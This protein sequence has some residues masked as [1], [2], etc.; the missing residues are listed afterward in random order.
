VIRFERKYPICRSLALSKGDEEEIV[1]KCHENVF[2]DFVADKC[3]VDGWDSSFTTDVTLL[4]HNNSMSTAELL[5]GF[6]QFY[7][8]FDFRAYVLC[9][10]LGLAV[11]VAAFT[12]RQ[13]SDHAVKHFKV[14]VIGRRLVVLVALTN[15]SRNLI[16]DRSS[17]SSDF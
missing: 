15:Q 5:T 2:V 17:V 1:H 16:V 10:R 11:N 6:L 3:I 14:C 8:E 12:E 7:A 9:P 13:Q 4:Q